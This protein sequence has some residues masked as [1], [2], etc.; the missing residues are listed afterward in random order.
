MPSV[1]DQ[2]GQSFGIGL[3]EELSAGRVLLTMDGKIAQQDGFSQ[4]AGIFHDRAPSL[5]ERR[6]HYGQT[7]ADNL[8]LQTS[9][10]PA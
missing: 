7:A 3:R 9:R 8:N 6:L 5:E 10:D 1:G 4:D 2:I